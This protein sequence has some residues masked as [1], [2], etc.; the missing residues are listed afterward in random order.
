MRKLIYTLLALLLCLSCAAAEVYV[1]LSTSKLPEM[2][3]APQCPEII[4]VQTAEDSV[5]ITLAEPLPDN[6]QV[7]AWLRDA[8]HC[9]YFYFATPDDVSTYTATVPVPTPGDEWTGFDI[10]WR[11]R[12]V[13]AEAHYNAAGGLESVTR[14]DNNYNEYIFD[15]DLRFCEFAY[16]ESGVRARFN[17]R[18]VMTSYGYEAFRD[19]IVWFSKNGEVVCAEYNDGDGGI[20]ARW[21]PGYGWFV[22]TPEGRVKIKLDVPSPWDAQRLLKPAEPAEVAEVT[23][24]PN[25]T[26]CVAGLT[27][28]E[29]DPSL[30]EKWYNVLPIDLTKDGR[31]VYQLVISNMFYIGEVYVD[32]WGDE[33]TVSCDLVDSTAVQ[34]LSWYG[35]WFTR[36]GD[37]TTASIESSEDGIPF[38]QPL[39]IADDLGGADTALLFIR[40]K[41]TYYQPFRDGTTLTRYWRNLDEWKEFRE[42][43]QELMPRVA[44]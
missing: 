43:L 11:S 19:M 32:V 22:D 35:R 10:F 39:S 41:A 8:D 21:E 28:K 37:I 44:K 6:A 14:Y 34:P 25:N 17:T 40:S 2:L 16:A 1:P 33:V 9:H 5:T 24:Y 18:G 42:G 20:A 23:H 38:G 26:I 31:S 30:P 15:N 4:R 7:T 3:S 27:L 36:L 12:D 29:A 13:H